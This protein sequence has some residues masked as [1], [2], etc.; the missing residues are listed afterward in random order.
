MAQTQR[1]TSDQ[2]PYVP[3][4]G[5]FG[6]IQSEVPLDFMEGLGVADALNVIFRQSRCTTR[7][8]YTALPALPGGDPGPIMGIFDF[9]NAVGV[10]IQCVITPTALYTWNGSAW[11]VIVG[12]LTGGPAQLFSFSVLNYKLCF[13]QGADPVQLYD[14]ITPTFNPAAVAAVPGKFLCQVSYHLLT[15]YTVELSVVRPQRI[16]WTGVFDPTDWTSFNSGFIDLT[17]DLGPI[18]GL[19]NVYQTGFAFQQKGITQIVPT[20]VGTQPFNFVQLSSKAK[21]NICPFSLAYYGDQIACYVGQDNIYLFDSVQSYP[22]GDMPMGGQGPTRVGARS[23]IF[24]EL[25]LTNLNLVYGF[26]TTTIAG[27]PFNAYW[28]IIPGGS[29]WVYHFDELCWSRFT[30]TYNGAPIQPFVVGDFDNQA[31]IRIMDLIGTIA[32]QSWSPDTLIDTSPLNDIAIGFQNGVV[33]DINFTNFSETEWSITS[34][35]IRFQDSRNTKYLNRMRIVQQGLLNTPCSYNVVITN[36]DGFVQPKNPSQSNDFGA[37]QVGEQLVD[38]SQN[39]LYFQYVI[40]SDET[41]SPVSIVEIGF[42]TDTGQ[43]YR[44][45]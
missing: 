37:G 3:F 29:V 43:P 33:G 22:I 31:G 13:S 21:G 26:I 36:N 39:A 35:S 23:R 11:T 40:S 19:A 5:P 27:N 32:Q 12:A 38:M 10:R 45:I 8:G 15:A 2:V 7:P 16:R 44:G 30:Y 4:R 24:A 9:F 42:D 20:G 34:G 18:T 6:G 28:L 41:L 17:N 14:G 1:D 25:K